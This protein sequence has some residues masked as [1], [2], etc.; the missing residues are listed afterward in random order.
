MRK[1]K[2]RENHKWKKAFL[3]MLHSFSHPRTY[4]S[5]FMPHILRHYASYSSEF[6]NIPFRTIFNALF[7]PTLCG[8]MMEILK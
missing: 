3:Y 6:S 2:M 4:S 1:R 7:A 5:F 8:K